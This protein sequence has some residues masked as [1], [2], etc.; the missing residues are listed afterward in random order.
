MNDEAE[1]EIQRWQFTFFSFVIFSYT[2]TGMA[3][4]T[5]MSLIKYSNSHVQIICQMIIV[6][7]K[8]RTIKKITA[9]WYV[10]HDLSKGL[11]K[12]RPKG[13]IDCPPSVKKPRLILIYTEK[14][15]PDKDWLN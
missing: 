7:Y 3:T 5:A 12:L 9:C 10:Y 14:A 1:L 4:K 15:I 13:L 6:W 2:P 8:Y 11:E